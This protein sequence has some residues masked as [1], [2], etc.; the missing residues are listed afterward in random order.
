MAPPIGESLHE[1]RA[2]RGI[3]LIDVE[4]AT[5]IRVE[6]LR[7]MEE[8]RWELLP[9]AA[10]A[11]GFLRTYGNFLGLDGQALVE[12]YGHRRSRSRTAIPRTSPSSSRRPGPGGPA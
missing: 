12:E 10:Y 4:R 5:K 7:A 1:A 2:R 9:G 6:Y 3:E 8:E 11:R